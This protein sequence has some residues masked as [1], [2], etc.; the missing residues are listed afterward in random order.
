VRV[1]WIGVSINK[2]KVQMLV[3]EAQQLAFFSN[4]AATFTTTKRIDSYNGLGSGT[5]HQR[6][7]RTTTFVI[8]STN[9]NAPPWPSLEPFEF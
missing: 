4:Q 7:T 3:K 2:G 8:K 9:A 6:A 1:F 5:L